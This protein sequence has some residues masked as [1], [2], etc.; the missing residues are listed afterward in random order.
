VACDSA[1]RNGEKGK[2]SPAYLVGRG[3]FTVAH[4]VFPK[5][6][7]MPLLLACST[8][9]RQRVVLYPSIQTSKKGGGV[10]GRATDGS[11]YHSAKKPQIR[12]KAQQVA[13]PFIILPQL[14]ININ[15]TIL[16]THL[17]SLGR[18]IE[19]AYFVGHNEH[20]VVRLV[21]LAW[22]NSLSAARYRQEACHRNAQYPCEAHRCE[23]K[24]RAFLAHRK[25]FRTA[26]RRQQCM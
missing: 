8:A 2:G 5:L 26:A 13:N 6:V 20:G 22:R 16:S 12:S 24:G 9:K 3:H 25:G 4:E 18:V 7:V 14:S 21:M 1:R 17:V 23:C 15:H 10:S 11:F 19:R